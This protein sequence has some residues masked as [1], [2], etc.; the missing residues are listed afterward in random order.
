MSCLSPRSA[1]S[2]SCPLSNRN[3][4]TFAADH[5]F[6]ATFRRADEARELALEVTDSLS[7]ELGHHRESLLRAFVKMDANGD[8][9]L[10]TKE[11]QKGLRQRGMQLTDKEMQGLMQV[12]DRDGDGT[13]DYK[14]FMD[15]VGRPS[16]SRSRARFRHQS[17]VRGLIS[18]ILGR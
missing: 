6:I 4:R 5:E 7:R 16:H 17:G 12:V 15:A 9:V 18:R 10:T 8:G 1:R 14:E 13:L 11:F 2:C 3:R